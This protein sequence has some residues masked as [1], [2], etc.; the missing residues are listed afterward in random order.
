MFLYGF[1]RFPLIFIGFLRFFMSSNDSH[2]PKE[3]KPLQLSAQTAVSP[4]PP[5]HLENNACANGARIMLSAR[6]RRRNGASGL[7]ARPPAP[8]RRGAPPHRGAGRRGRGHVFNV[9]LLGG[10]RWR[11]NVFDVSPFSIAPA[12]FRNILFNEMEETRRTN[13]SRHHPIAR[14]TT[15]VQQKPSG[16]AGSAPTFARLAAHG[17]AAGGERAT[18]H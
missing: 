1:H 11:G 2:C 4:P 16:S 18:A 6:G 17:P 7:P 5:E 13:S 15:K 9:K 8:A 12:N 3:R 10:R 14:R